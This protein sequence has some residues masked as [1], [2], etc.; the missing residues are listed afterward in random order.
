MISVHKN[1]SDVSSVIVVK[2][3]FC[4]KFMIFGLH[5]VFAV[6]FNFF[7]HAFALLGHEQH[8]SHASSDRMVK[9]NFSIKFM[10]LGL[11]VV[12]VV[13]CKF[14]VEFF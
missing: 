6:K 12:F 9:L 2:L 3:S 4:S 10:I 7:F 11:H 13:K 5:M 1:N 14:W 8:N